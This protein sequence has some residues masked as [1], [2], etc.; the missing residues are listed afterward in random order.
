MTSAFIV[1]D[2]TIRG[3]S[4]EKE[5]EPIL[6]PA[7]QNVLDGLAQHDGQNCTVCCRI[8]SRDRGK[9]SHAVGKENDKESLKV[10]RLIPVSERMPPAGEWNEE[11]TVR[12][13]QPPA[14]ALAV[15]M[16]G[17]EDELSHLKMYAVSPPLHF[18]F[19]RVANY[20]CREL[21]QYQKAYN[22]H[23]ASL[24]KRK[25][26][27][28]FTKIEALLRAID[29]KADQIYA[30]YDVLEGQ[31]AD[32]HEITEEEVEVTLHSI[33][34]NPVEL[35]LRGHEMKYAKRSRVTYADEGQSEGSESSAEEGETGNGDDDMELP[36]EG[37]EDTDV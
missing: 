16:K 9:E 12:P 31:K 20:L 14:T 29:A 34:I 26:K 24:S 37:I 33:G 15:V 5:A 11:P 35:G 7:A 2:I 3:L 13:S 1:P 4:T 21:A 22:S 10:P 6:S 17:L 32:G 36:W 18:I 8:V 30:L 19:G 23:D 25:R 28:I 27:S